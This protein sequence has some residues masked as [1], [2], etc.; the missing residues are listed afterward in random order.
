MRDENMN[1]Y[2]KHFSHLPTQ[3][4]ETQEKQAWKLFNHLQNQ[5]NDQVLKEDYLNQ[6]QICQLIMIT[7]KLHHLQEVKIYF[8][9][10]QN[11]KS[12]KRKRKILLEI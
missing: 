2:V 5:Y 1:Y 7:L 11:L 12:W 9:N 10:L 4:V 6:K 8:Q 3:Q